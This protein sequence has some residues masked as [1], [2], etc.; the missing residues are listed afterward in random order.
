VI[1]ITTELQF[2]GTIVAGV[3]GLVF[4]SFLNVFLARFPE[5]E[6]IVTPRSHCRNCD[7]TLAWW[8][9]IPLLSWLLLRGRC[10]ACRNRIGFRY[11]LVELV[12]G[13][14]WAA[15]WMKFSAP[16]FSVPNP[17][18]EI[19]YPITQSLPQNVIE[20]L[21][22]AL[23]SWLLVA[24]AALDAEYLWLPDALTLPGIGLGFCFTL[25]RN[26]ISHE[27]DRSA[28][29]LHSAWTS[30]LAVLASAGIVLF[31][32][33]AY[34]LVRRREGMGLGDVKLM[35]LLGAWLGLGGAM[36]SFVLSVFAATIAAMVWL[37]ILVVRRKTSEWATMPLPLGTFL[38]VAAFSE[39]FYPNWIWN[40]LHLNIWS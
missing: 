34:W 25:L 21:G 19:P 7:H 23:L 29:L 24:L 6:S 20:T 5:G 16:L 14:L 13:L 39:V 3:F 35:A 10:R 38:C 31:I 12:L 26:W 2:A 9:N 27:A 4:G 11:P 33:L 30:A 8:E 15:L 22:F 28:N 1:E 18:N 37:V 32:R 36:E 17:T 40:G